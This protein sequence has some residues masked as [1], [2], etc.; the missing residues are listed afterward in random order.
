[1]KRTQKDTCLNQRQNIAMRPLGS[2]LFVA[3]LSIG[4]IAIAA[5]AE[6]TSNMEGE[7]RYSRQPNNMATLLNEEK[8]ADVPEEKE[9]NFLDF[10]KDDRFKA[11]LGLTS[12]GGQA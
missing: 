2:M 4:A 7:V 12:V 3:C 1:M 6:S 11:K 5:T 9:K 10:L 8:K